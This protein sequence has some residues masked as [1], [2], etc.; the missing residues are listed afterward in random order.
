[1]AL[2]GYVTLPGEMGDLPVRPFPVARAE[3]NVPDA[4]DG[5]VPVVEGMWVLP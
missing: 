5:L 3:E 1:M 2:P 4:S